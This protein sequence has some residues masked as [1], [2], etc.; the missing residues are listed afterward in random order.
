MIFIKVVFR[1]SKIIYTQ[2]QLRILFAKKCRRI[3]IKYLCYEVIF[4]LKSIKKR[5]WRRVASSA[6][7]SFEGLPLAYYFSTHTHNNIISLYHFSPLDEPP[8]RII[9]YQN[10]TY[11]F[12]SF[13]NK[14]KYWL[15][16][17]NLEAGVLRGK[18]KLIFIVYPAEH[19]SLVDKAP[20]RHRVVVL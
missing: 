6:E 8:C 7:H 16:F 14:M 13:Q 4:L 3:K 1:Y 15:L 20:R 11:T 17:I 18:R 2:K 5:K 9:I 12:F 10:N 19:F